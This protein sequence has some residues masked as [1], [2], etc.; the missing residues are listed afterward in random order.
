METSIEGKFRVGDY[1][2]TTF[3]VGKKYLKGTIRKIVV[4]GDPPIG[5]EIPIGF[6]GGHN[7]RGLLPKNNGWFFYDKQLV[8]IKRGTPE[9]AS[10]IKRDKTLR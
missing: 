3:K 9:I 2:E 7:L 8:L 5:V 1:V 10:S 6:A 4:N